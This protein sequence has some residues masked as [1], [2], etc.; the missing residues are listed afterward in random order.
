MQIKITMRYHLTPVR[1]AI[2][3]K[4][5]NNKCQRRCGEKGTPYTV[6]VYSHYGE[7][8]NGELHYVEIP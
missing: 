3:K 8:Y 2:V 7:L 1:I 5:I 4:S 6:G